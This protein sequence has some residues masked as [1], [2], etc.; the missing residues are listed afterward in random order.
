MG[1]RSLY[2][3]LLLLFVFTSCGDD[4]PKKAYLYSNPINASPQLRLQCESYNNE[5]N[6][7]KI[8][9]G[10]LNN[11]SLSTELYGSCVQGSSWRFGVDSI[12]V[13]NNCRAVFNLYGY[14]IVIPI[15]YVPDNNSY[16]PSSTVITC[17]PANGSN[18]NS[19]PFSL[20]KITSVSVLKK[21]SSASC[22][23]DEGDWGYTKDSIWVANGCRAKFTVGY[24][25]N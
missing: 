16:F 20:G 25:S 12:S 10:T 21:L 18:E 14:G 23:E 9:Q 3:G 15:Q 6:T 4:E 11:V 5:T 22:L 1:N 8:S 19:C 7:C 17:G 24:L 2:V 13:W